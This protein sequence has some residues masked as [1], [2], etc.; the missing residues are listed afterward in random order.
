MTLIAGEVEHP[1]DM[2]AL[3]LE[4]EQVRHRLHHDTYKAEESCL[5]VPTMHRSLWCPLKY[6]IS[7][8]LGNV[9]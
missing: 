5:P 7:S 2:E 6:D 1:E 9:C 8:L 4:L 3:L